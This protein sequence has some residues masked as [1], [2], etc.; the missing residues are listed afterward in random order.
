MKRN[1][2]SV[3]VYIIFDYMSGYISSNFYK[4]FINVFQVKILTKPCI[5]VQITKSYKNATICLM[6]LWRMVTSLAIGC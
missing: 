1:C 5:C 6:K 3:A 4:H 2:E